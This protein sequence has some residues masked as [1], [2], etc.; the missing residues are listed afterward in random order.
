MRSDGSR[1][2]RV[3][4]SPGL[5]LSNPDFSPDDRELVFS[6]SSSGIRVGKSPVVTYRVGIEGGKLRRVSSGV[7]RFSRENPEWVR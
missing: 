7:L 2:H 6:D 3:A 1:A 4:G 5:N